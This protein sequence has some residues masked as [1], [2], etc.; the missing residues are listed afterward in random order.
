[1]DMSG[2]LG[3][4]RSTMA[5]AWVIAGVVSMVVLGPSFSGAQEAD[6]VKPQ[7]AEARQHA[8]DASGDQS[9]M[10][11]HCQEM[12]DK[13]DARMAKTQEMAAAADKRMGRMEDMM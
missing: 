7:Q 4:I 6:S 2:R 3:R 5:L 13:M 8:S 1:M 11:K 9:P 10:M 12:M